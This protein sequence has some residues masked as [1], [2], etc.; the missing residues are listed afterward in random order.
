MG[1]TRGNAL[2]TKEKDKQLVE[3]QSVNTY[4]YLL[5]AQSKKTSTVN[6]ENFN[7]SVYEIP[8]V[9]HFIQLT[10][11][12]FLKKSYLKFFFCYHQSKR[13]HYHTTLYLS[14]SLYSLLT[15][16]VKSCRVQI[17]QGSMNEK[18]SQQQPSA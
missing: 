10:H 4:E 7:R 13:H 1:M 18:L 3:V 16:G 14:G 5:Y 12:R 2:F 8:R 9:S 17:S 11:F 15:F 6:G